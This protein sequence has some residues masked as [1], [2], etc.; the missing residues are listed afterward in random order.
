MIAK[1]MLMPF[2]QTVSKAS[3]L[4]GFAKRV[5]DRL[6]VIVCGNEIWSKTAQ[7]SVFHKA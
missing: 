3:R 6:G 2:L 7:Q 1:I 5:A 4:V